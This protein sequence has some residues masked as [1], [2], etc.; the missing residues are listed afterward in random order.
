MQES[1]E[2]R[3]ARL[4]Y[5]KAWRKKNKKRIKEYQKQWQGENP[6][7]LKEYQKRYWEKKIAENKVD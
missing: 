1:K 3:E 6:K 7:K 2:A 4:E 5:L